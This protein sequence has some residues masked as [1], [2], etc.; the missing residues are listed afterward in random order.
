MYYNCLA[1]SFVNLCKKKV[2]L[3]IKNKYGAK[4]PIKYL[5][6]GDNNCTPDQIKCKNI[7]AN[8]RKLS[9][10]RQLSALDW[11]HRKTTFL[12]YNIFEPHL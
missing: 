1:L 11:V 12:P 4:Q 10:L 5:S 8:T 9:G 7:A 6:P 3:E 2:R